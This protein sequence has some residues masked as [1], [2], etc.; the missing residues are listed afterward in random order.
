MLQ[1]LST[2]VSIH[3]DSD[4]PSET[5]T[6]LPVDDLTRVFNSVL[7]SSRIQAERDYSTE[8]YDVVQSAPFRAI[9]GGVKT[10]ARNSGISERLAAEQLIATFR[11]I[12]Q[13]WAGYI[14]Q[15]GVEKLQ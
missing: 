10:L 12:D 11:K 1:T 4:F 13:I 6:S 3:S 7:V 2:P 15:E 8:L 9:L 14:T 5:S